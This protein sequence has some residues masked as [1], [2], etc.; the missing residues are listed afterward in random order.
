MNHQQVQLGL[1]VMCRTGW[2]VAI[3]LLA[4]LHGAAAKMF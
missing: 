1:A 4:Q 2:L 3:C